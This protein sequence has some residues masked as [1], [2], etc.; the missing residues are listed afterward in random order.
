MQRC[1]DTACKHISYIMF[2]QK[3][4]LESSLRST[5]SS[6]GEP[7]WKHHTPHVS[8]AKLRQV[9][10][11]LDLDNGVVERGLQALGHHVGQD[12]CHHHRQDVG[13]LA[14]QL[15]ADNCRGHCVSHSPG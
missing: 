10:Q 1:T 14:C 2:Q 13:D 8:E 5:F 4:I 9:R 6:R 3:S 11:L 12:Y 7:L 15:E